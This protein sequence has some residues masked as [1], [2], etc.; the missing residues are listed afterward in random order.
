[1]CALRGA[2]VRKEASRTPEEAPVKTRPSVGSVY[3]NPQQPP[4]PRR[5]S[6]AT[7]TLQTA[8][9]EET[10]ETQ[11][12]GCWRDQLCLWVAWGEAASRKSKGRACSP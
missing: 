12:G 5:R 10:Q 2:E 8:A 6:H 3:P 1:M 9:K 11:E 7:R 4:T